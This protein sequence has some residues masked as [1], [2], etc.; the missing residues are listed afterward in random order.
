MTHFV[1]SSILLVL[2]ATTLCRVSA[3]AQALSGT[4]FGAVTSTGGAAIHA[5]TVTVTESNSGASRVTRTNPA[6]IYSFHDLP[7]GTYTVEIAASGF[8]TFIRP[9]VAVAVAA[10]VRVDATLQTSEADG[11]RAWSGEFSHNAF[12]RVIAFRT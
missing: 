11:S 6:G 9:E 12:H 8:R 1:S 3:N 10:T 7:P 2:L 4:L 5:A